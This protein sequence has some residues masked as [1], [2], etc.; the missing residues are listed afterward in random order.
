MR[1]S[2]LTSATRPGL[3]K[4]SNREIVFTPKSRAIPSSTSGSPPVFAV[5]E[6]RRKEP[7]RYLVLGQPVLSKQKEGALVTDTREY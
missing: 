4:S 7:F 5:D 6:I 3:S 1:S 2:A